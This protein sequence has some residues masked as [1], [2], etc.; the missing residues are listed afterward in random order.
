MESNDV[1]LV[2]LLF[3]WYDGLIN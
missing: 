3:A 1:L 2:M